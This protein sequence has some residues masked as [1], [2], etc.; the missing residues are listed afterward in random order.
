MIFSFYKL[1]CYSISGVPKRCLD[2][3]Q[4][5]SCHTIFFLGTPQPVC[6]Y[7]IGIYKRTVIVIMSRDAILY[8]YQGSLIVYFIFDHFCVHSLKKKCN[9]FFC[10][11]FSS[12]LQRTSQHPLMAPQRSSTP[13]L[14]TTTL[15]SP[16]LQF[17]CLHL[18]CSSS[19]THYMFAV[20]NN[21]QHLQNR[22]KESVKL[23][24]LSVESTLQ[25]MS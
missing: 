1:T 5:G 16:Q 14:K 19:Y 3:V 4:Y 18:S 6:Q 9:T 15:S 22:S 24:S 17:I 8:Y 23:D 10:F 11:T 2:K 13:T 20:S 7:P 25:K 21:R 12:N